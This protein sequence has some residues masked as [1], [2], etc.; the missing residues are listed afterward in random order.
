[1]YSPFTKDFDDFVAD[2]FS[3]Y[4]L[5]DAPD[6]AM[7]RAA[8]DGISDPQREAIKVLTKLFGDMG[9]DAKFYGL[10]P[11]FDDISQ[12]ISK[13]KT[14]FD[15]KAKVIA[16]I[17]KKRRA[18]GT[19]SAKANK[20]LLQ[21][22]SEQIALKGR[23]DM[24]EDALT[25][26]PRK[27]FKFGI[28][29]NKELLLSDDAAREGLTRKFEDHYFRQR[30]QDENLTY[31]EAKAGYSESVREDAERTLKRILEEDA[32]DL[33]D[34]MPAPDIKGGSKHLAHRKTNIPEHEVLDYMH[35]T[36]DALHAYITRMGKQIAF[37]QK[38]GGRNI[39]EVLAD[40]TEE[41]KRLAYLQ[42]RLLQ[43][44]QHLLATIAA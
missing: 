42:R 25:R 33:E 21:L 43:H 15:D 44:E 8:V 2:T 12:K 40:M 41:M 30:M 32:D 26:P 16:D 4:I 31:A 37:A 6:P 9:E 23:I 24:L 1:V 11:S 14:Q 39:D 10:F 5:S 28:Y 27:D 17:E 29:Y 36:M 38:F 34:L 18:D 22:E 3:R 20:T 19:L 7:R 35:L 13:A